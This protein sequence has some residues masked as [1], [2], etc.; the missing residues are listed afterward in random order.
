MNF[1][2]CIFLLSLLATNLAFAQGQN[3]L[4]LAEPKIQS[5]D[6]SAVVKLEFENTF[7]Q[8]V[9]AIRAMIILLDADGKAVGHQSQ[10]LGGNSASKQ[11]LDFE[12]GETTTYPIKVKTNATATT[13]TVLLTRIILEDGTKPNP[14]RSFY[15][16]VEMP[17]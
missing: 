9:T 6:G 13:A 17:Q 10:W 11:Q 3:K 12:P 2:F 5:L 16:R 1:R 14:I 4:L 7:E 8:P 15:K